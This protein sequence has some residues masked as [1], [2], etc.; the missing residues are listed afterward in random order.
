MQAS[1]RAFCELWSCCRDG[2]VQ[3]YGTSADENRN[4]EAGVS[5]A[6]SVGVN[7]AVSTYVGNDAF[8]VANVDLMYGSLERQG[9]PQVC[10]L[11]KIRMRKLE[12]E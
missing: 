12:I 3:V 6:M 5:A 9:H 1:F 10:K 4:L 7:S 2:D 8:T 11:L